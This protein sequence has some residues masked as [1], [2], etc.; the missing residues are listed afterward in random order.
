MCK[1]TKK[2]VKSEIALFGGRFG[3]FSWITG[4]TVPDMNTFRRNLN[5]YFSLLFPN[6]IDCKV[7]IPVFNTK[8]IQ[9]ISLQ[10]VCLNHLVETV[11][12]TNE[13]ESGSSPLP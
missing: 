13:V 2:K 6:A 11:S 10:P 1:Y 3:V 9:L 12:D 4:L 5:V 7:H 8:T